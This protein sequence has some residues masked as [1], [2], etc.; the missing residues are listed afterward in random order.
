MR[1]E[2]N[3]IFLSLTSKTQSPDRIPASYAVDPGNTSLIHGYGSHGARLKCKPNAA[4]AF[5]CIQQSRNGASADDCDD[6]Y[7][8]VITSIHTTPE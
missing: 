2:F 7:Y 3:L 1:H 5:H 4:F 8:W 6:I